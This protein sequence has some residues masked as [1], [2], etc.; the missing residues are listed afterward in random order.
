MAKV[1][2]EQAKEQRSPHS[3]VGGGAED[4]ALVEGE[5]KVQVGQLGQSHPCREG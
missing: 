1:G 5:E 3:D 2:Y 4:E